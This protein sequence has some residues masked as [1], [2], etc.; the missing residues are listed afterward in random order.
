MCTN[1]GILATVTAQYFF[2]KVYFM[3][4]LYI[5]C[6]GSHDCYWNNAEEMFMCVV[7]EQT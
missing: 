5:L 7:L 3:Y 6:I 1:V 2:Y 4:L